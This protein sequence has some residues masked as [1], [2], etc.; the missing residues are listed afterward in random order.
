MNPPV[1][2]KPTLFKINKIDS[3]NSYYLIYS[4]KDN[5]KYKIVSKKD[6]RERIECKNVLK[7]NSYYDFELE[8]LIQEVESSN[9]LE[10]K[11]TFPVLSCYVFDDDTKICEENEMEILYKVKNLKGLC[12]E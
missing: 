7:E 1:L 5:K 12:L 4:V 6:T 2:E 11:P 10:N 8:N 9:P 3:I